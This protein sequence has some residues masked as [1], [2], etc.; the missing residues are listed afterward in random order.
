MHTYNCL[1]NIV[2]GKLHGETYITALQLISHTDIHVHKRMQV[3]LGL[4]TSP[5]ELMR[6]TSLDFTIMASK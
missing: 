5:G 1:G 3:E 4:S 6:A 2:A